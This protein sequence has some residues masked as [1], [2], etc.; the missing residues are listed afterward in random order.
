GDHAPPAPALSQARDSGEAAVLSRDYLRQPLEAARCLEAGGL[1]IEAIA[2]YE[3]QGR[4]ETAGDLDSRLGQGD[5][6]IQADR[7]ASDKFREAGDIL[8]SAMLLC[9]KIGAPEEA[10]VLYSAAWPASG[11][12][13]PC[14][15]ALFA[16]LGRLGRHEDALRY[17]RK[18]REDSVPPTMALPLA[19]V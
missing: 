17:L 14:L 16:W 15:K 19:T 6:A 3:A 13:E 5:A 8:S 1:L 4:L 9:E 10:I 12:A 7:S 2:I 18:L 11:Q